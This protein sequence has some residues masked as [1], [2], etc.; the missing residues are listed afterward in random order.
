MRPK[1]PTQLGSA[2]MSATRTDLQKLEIFGKVESPSCLNSECALEAFVVGE[3]TVVCGI[4]AYKSTRPV[5]ILAPAHLPR[6]ALTYL[7]SQRLL[8]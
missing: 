6:V 3:N 1:P 4:H 8:Y 2:I 5:L 7:P